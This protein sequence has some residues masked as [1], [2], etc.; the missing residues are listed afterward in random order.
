MTK[1]YLALAAFGLLVHAETSWGFAKKPMQITELKGVTETQVASGENKASVMV[2]GKAAELLF[3]VMKEKQEEQTDT[4]ALKW[5]GSKDGAEWTVKG[6]QITC[7]KIA[8][9]TAEDYACAFEIDQTGSLAAANDVYVPDTF[10]L[11]RTATGSKV[12][13]SK[14]NRAIA[15]VAPLA[16]Y[17]KGLAYLVYD[18]PGQA[19]KSENAM[20]VFK[21][22]SAKELLGLLQTGPGNKDAHWGD[23]TGRKGQDIACVGAS[24]GQPD[25]CAVVV[26]FKDGS[27]TH[28][29]NPLFR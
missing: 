14:K 17:S 25:R 6:K 27:V 23:A 2:R 19:K 9:K 15:S 18:E 7:S 20:I 12:F 13:K 16:A 22:D 28:S 26:S 8:K 29:G 4:E 5:I 11:T 3:K 10:N 1:S 24:K 21:G